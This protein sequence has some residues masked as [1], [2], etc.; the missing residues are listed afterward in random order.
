M[1][2]LLILT[3]PQ[4]SG[5]HVFSKCLAVHEDVHGWKSL[6]NEYWEGHHREPFADMWQDTELLREFDWTQS[7][8]FVTSVSCPY[9][10]NRVPVVP[11]Y[12]KFISIA[13]EY[14]DSVDI[15]IIGRDQNILKY[16]QQRIRKVH[17][18][19]IATEN[20]KWLLKNHSC[21]FLSQELLYLYR[22]DYLEQ[23]S[24]HLDWPIAHWDPE[25]EEI[26]KED[27]NEK[28]IKPAEPHWLDFEV[29]QA[30]KES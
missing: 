12:K 8:H 3:G 2:R 19:P 18:T 25:I 21:S 14:V 5:N 1:S 15:A 11:D 4:G 22:S 17:T 13:K 10:K 7:E 20:F 30:V 28:Y 26:L 29:E 27:A 24:K 16:Q 23:V 9:F 6:L